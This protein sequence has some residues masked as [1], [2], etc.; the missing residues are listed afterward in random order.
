VGEPATSGIAITPDGTRL[1]VDDGGDNRIFEIDTTQN[2]IVNTTRA[3]QTAGIMAITPDS[4]EL[5]VG[6]YSSTFASVINISSGKVI[7]T[8]PLGNQS[9]GIAFAPQ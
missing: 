5:W 6:D 8:V 9:Y 7:R 3:G 4:G 1:F 2:R